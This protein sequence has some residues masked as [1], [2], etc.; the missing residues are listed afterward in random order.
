MHFKVDST[1][2]SDHF[3]KRNFSSY[4]IF[5]VPVEWVKT[6]CGPADWLKNLKN[7]QFRRQRAKYSHILSFWW[8]LNL[9]RCT[10]HLKFMLTC[11][12]TNSLSMEKKWVQGIT[13]N[14]LGS[15]FLSQPIRGQY[16]ILPLKSVLTHEMIVLMHIL[17]HIWAAY[18]VTIKN[19]PPDIKIFEKIWVVP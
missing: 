6:Y 18:Q 10:P 8:F 7:D 5:K 14:N 4:K 17:M 19:L 9:R 11:T 2:V 1:L 12:T 3:V 15:H 16:F 13:R